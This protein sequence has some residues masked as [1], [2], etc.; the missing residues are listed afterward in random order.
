M[1][2]AQAQ[3]RT[4]NFPEG[5]TPEQMGVAI[6]EFF[7]SQQGAE[8]DQQDLL[9]PTARQELAPE[10]QQQL[11]EARPAQLCAAPGGTGEAEAVAGRTSKQE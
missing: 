6:D 2:I 10:Q 9:S 1:P 4:F 11:L 8:P 5:I 3:G 7:S